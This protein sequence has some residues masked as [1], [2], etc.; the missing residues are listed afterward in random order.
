MQL[1]LMLEGSAHCYWVWV[2]GRDVVEY[3][4][5]ELLGNYTM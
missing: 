1:I 2:R 3:V 5:G 4:F